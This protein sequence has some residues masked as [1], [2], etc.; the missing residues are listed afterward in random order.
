MIRLRR[1]VARLRRGGDR[2]AGGAERERRLQEAADRLG[3]A[4]GDFYPPESDVLAVGGEPLDPEIAERLDASREELLTYIDRLR[5]RR[6]RSRTVLLATIGTL[7]LLAVPVVAAMEALDGRRSADQEWSRWL[8]PTKPDV[9][10]GVALPRFGSS[11]SAG[12]P[13]SGGRVVATAYV[14]VRGDL[15]TAIAFVDAGVTSAKTVGRCLDL[16]RLAESLPRRALPTH[17]ATIGGARVLAGIVSAR[18]RPVAR[19]RARRGSGV[20]LSGVWRIV[21]DGGSPVALR[22]FLQRGV[23][24]LLQTN[25]MTRHVESNISKGRVWQAEDARR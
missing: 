18:G 2:S 21:G 15:C 17:A 1:A 10:S 5:Q 19:W 4:L 14:D 23:T 3:V 11:A 24:N 13:L 22:V 9:R 8:E 25:D 12:L 20:A 7:G 6:R 16:R